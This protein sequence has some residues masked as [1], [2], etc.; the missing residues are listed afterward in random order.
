MPEGI[1][2][3]EYWRALFEGNFLVGDN[4]ALEMSGGMFR[5]GCPGCGSGSSCRIISLYM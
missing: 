2:I 3:G 4:F 1:F 5:E